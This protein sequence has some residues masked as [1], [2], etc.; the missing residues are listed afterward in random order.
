MRA[1][2]PGAGGLPIAGSLDAIADALAAGT[3]VVVDLTGAASA[4]ASGVFRALV[5]GRALDTRLSGDRPAAGGIVRLDLSSIPDVAA[6]DLYVAVADPEADGFLTAFACDAERPWVSS[7][8]YAAGGVAGNHVS[9]AVGD[10]H[11]VCL[12]TLRAT[13]VIVDVEGVHVAM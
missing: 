10:D 6:V 8:N 1:L 7:L 13:D 9:V 5:S 3:D 4:R 12:Y 11:Q 2:P